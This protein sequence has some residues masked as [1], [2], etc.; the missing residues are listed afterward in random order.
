[1]VTE[2][3]GHEIEEE[4]PGVEGLMQAWEVETQDGQGSGRVS[5][6]FTKLL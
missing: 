6:V 2:Y 4:I 5:K 3:I 1:M